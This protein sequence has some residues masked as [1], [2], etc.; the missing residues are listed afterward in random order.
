[1]KLGGRCPLE[2]KRDP[3]SFVKDQIIKFNG[4]SFEIS[5]IKT[6]N[7]KKYYCRNICKN[8]LC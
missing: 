5:K 7:L 6:K 8:I 4:G 1:M 2:N 3:D